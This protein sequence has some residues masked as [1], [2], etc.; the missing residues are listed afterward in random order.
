MDLKELLGEELYNQVIEKVGDKHKIALVS[1][2]NWIPKDKFNEINEAKKQLETDIKTRDQQ[3]TDLKKSAGDHEELKKQIGQLQTENKTKDDDYKAKIK[4]LSINSAIKL[5]LGNDAHDSEMV[6][7]LVDKSK[8]IL[9]EDGKVTGLDE[10]IKSLR[11]S[12]AFLFVPAPDPNQQQQQQTQF[13]G[14]KPA[15]GA[16]GTGGA[17]PPDFSKMTDAEYYTH[18]QNQQKK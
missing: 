17:Q 4:D 9:G 18:L 6:A 7:G 11:E 10:Q 12:K 5:T 16:G 1:D 8:L 2:G 15:E 13:R 14:A 3:L